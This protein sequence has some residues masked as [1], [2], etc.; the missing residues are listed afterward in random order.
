[1]DEEHDG[2]MLLQR[3]NQKYLVIAKISYFSVLLGLL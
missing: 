1:M 3:R 2:I